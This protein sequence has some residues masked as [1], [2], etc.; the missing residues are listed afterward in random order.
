MLVEPRFSG[1]IS[2]IQK[3][4]MKGQVSAPT[5]TTQTIGR[6]IFNTFLVDY[7]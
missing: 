7:V 6:N 2:P 5:S 3:G 1:G 4:A